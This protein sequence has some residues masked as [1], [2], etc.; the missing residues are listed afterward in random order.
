MDVDVDAVAAALGLGPR[1]ESWL[2][3]L[4]EIDPVPS[5]ALPI[6][7]EAAELLVRL[8]VPDVDLDAVL[9]VWPDGERDAE[10]WWLLERCQAR[11][12]AAMGDG[13]AFIECPSLPR[14]LDLQ[15]RCFWIF[16]FASMV[17]AT[18][19]YHRALDVPDDISWATLADLGQQL[20]V[21]RNRRGTTGLDLQ[22]WLVPHFLGALYGLGRLQFHLYHLRCGIAGP[23]FWP[24]SDEPGF[25]RGDA[26]LGVHIPATG[27][28]T[29]AEC[30]ASFERA[31]TFVRGRFPEHDFRVATCTSWLLDDQLADYLPADS[32]IVQFQRRFQVVDG[33]NDDG[34]DT[35][36][37]V[38]DRVPESIGDLPQR[39][40][41]ERAIV[42]HLRGGGRWRTRTGWLEP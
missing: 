2:T 17:D 1:Y 27:P 26:T 37:F 24:E 15:G 14:S 38:F 22:W 16:V 9:T 36:L 40:T 20:V 28:L 39:T 19:S 12:V 33:S 21:H 25:R 5:L 35:L 23:A 31:K 10:L 42:G 34:R 41:L 8:D 3:A 11:F 18:R 13:D 4:G 6:G 7:D 30:D 29:R 32:N